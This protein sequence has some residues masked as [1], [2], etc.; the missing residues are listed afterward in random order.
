[1]SCSLSKMT[2][3]QEQE[4]NDRVDLRDQHAVVQNLA[5]D[6]EFSVMLTDILTHPAKFGS[7]FMTCQETKAYCIKIL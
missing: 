1:M 6:S 2:N 5:T 3:T 7:I 4:Y